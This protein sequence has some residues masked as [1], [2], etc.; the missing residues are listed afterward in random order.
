MTVRY[1]QRAATLSR[2]PLSKGVGRARGR[3]HLP[4]HPRHRRVRDRQRQVQVVLKLDRLEQG[5]ERERT[6]RSVADADGPAP[7]MRHPLVRAPAGP[8]VCCASSPRGWLADETRV[9]G[10]LWNA[11]GDYRNLLGPFPVG[12]QELCKVSRTGTRRFCI[13]SHAKRRPCRRRRS[14]RRATT[15]RTFAGLPAAALVYRGHARRAHLCKKR[16]FTPS[17]EPCNWRHAFVWSPRRSA[18]SV[19]AS[20]MGEPLVVSDERSV[21][22]VSSC[23]H[24]RVWE[25]QRVVPGS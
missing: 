25:P 5:A 10:A 24:E 21:M 13:K 15:R 20:G 4:G 9:G 14:R 6:S 18:F 8:A 7:A 1:H 22:L 16:L 19:P 12:H 11:Q 23:K 3:Q 17:R 2:L